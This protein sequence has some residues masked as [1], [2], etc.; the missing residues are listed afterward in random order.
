MREG[1]AG[2]NWVFVCLRGGY[3][4]IFPFY[5]DLEK[6]LQTLKIPGKVLEFCPDWMGRTLGLES[7]WTSIKV[8]KNPWVGLLAASPKINWKLFKILKKFLKNVKTSSLIG[9]RS[10]NLLEKLLEVWKVSE[11]SCLG[12]TNLISGST[13]FFSKFEGSVGR[14]KKE[15]KKNPQFF[16]LALIINK[17]FL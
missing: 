10:L 8:L 14:K 5:E 1:T 15:N 16:A 11:I 9:C 3:I 2:G 7:P 17:S 6:A 12:Q 13:D 4:S